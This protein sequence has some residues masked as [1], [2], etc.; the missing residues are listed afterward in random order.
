MRTTSYQS[1]ETLYGPTL[2]PLN[3]VSLIPLKDGTK[4]IV[5]IL[6]LT[7][8]RKKIKG[9]LIDFY[10]LRDTNRPPIFKVLKLKDLGERRWSKVLPMLRQ[11]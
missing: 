1:I 11:E 6:S 9:C 3:N 7:L 4:V 2:M 8:K 5:K 10:T